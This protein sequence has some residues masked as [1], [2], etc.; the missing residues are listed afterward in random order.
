MYR[1]CPHCEFSRKVYLLDACNLLLSAPSAEGLFNMF[2]DFVPAQ[3]HNVWN[4]RHCWEFDTFNHV[5]RFYTYT[6]LGTHVWLSGCEGTKLCL[7]SGSCC[8][9]TDDSEGVVDTLIFEEELK[10]I[11]KSS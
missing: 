5:C 2:R 3:S 10:A 7:I 6:A 9:F 1:V 4:G 11:L 8:N